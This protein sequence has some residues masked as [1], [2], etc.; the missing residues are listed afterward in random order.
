MAGDANE[1]G[2]LPFGDPRGRREEARK[3]A[4]VPRTAEESNEGGAGF[5]MRV[6]VGSRQEGIDDRDELKEAV[7]ALWREGVSKDDRALVSS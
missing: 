2:A 6:E 5:T 7:G 3:Q 1:G 4:E